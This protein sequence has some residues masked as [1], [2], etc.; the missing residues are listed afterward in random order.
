MYIIYT[1]YTLLDPNESLTLGQWWNGVM[2]SIWIDC[3]NALN[4]YIW[5]MT[6]GVKQNLTFR[7]WKPAGLFKWK[8]RVANRLCWIISRFGNNHLYF[9]WNLEGCIYWSHPY[10]LGYSYHWQTVGTLESNKSTKLLHPGA[11][12]GRPTFASRWPRH[13]QTCTA[14]SHNG[15]GCYHTGSCTGCYIIILDTKGVEACYKAL[16]CPF[17]SLRLY[18]HVGHPTVFGENV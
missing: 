7:V 8:G 16:H 11:I 10:Q 9:V 3:Q 2:L 6:V 15:S 1:K 12:M 4:T 17:P 18:D 5:L 14:P 13:L